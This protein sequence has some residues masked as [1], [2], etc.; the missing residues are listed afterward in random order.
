MAQSGAWVS[1]KSV[2]FFRFIFKLHTKEI[3]LMII[4]S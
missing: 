4:G 3:K 1:F 2:D